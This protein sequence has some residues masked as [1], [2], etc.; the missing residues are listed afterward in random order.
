M[1]PQIAGGIPSTQ[2]L[3]DDRY[4][5]AIMAAY[6]GRATHRPVRAMA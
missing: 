5:E 2:P 3:G 4:S 1:K 6:I